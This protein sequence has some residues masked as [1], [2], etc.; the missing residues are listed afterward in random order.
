MV[1]EVSVQWQTALE[2]EKLKNQ[3]VEEIKNCSEIPTVPDLD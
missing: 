2:K 3:R 1:C